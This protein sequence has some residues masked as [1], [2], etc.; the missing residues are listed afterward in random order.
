MS[1]AQ[2]SYGKCDEKVYAK[3]KTGYCSTHYYRN[4]EGRNM[5][6]PKQHHRIGV[7]AYDNVMSQTRPNGDC[8][9]FTGFIAS[10]GY[11]RI[12]TKATGEIGAH[13]VIAEKHL[14]KSNLT[15]LHSC[16][17]PKCVNIKHL[18]YG[19]HKENG[20]D[21]AKRLRAK[22]GEDNPKSYLNEK[23][24]LSI[25]HDNRVARVIAEEYQCT[26]KTVSNIKTHR[27]WSWLTTAA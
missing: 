2:C 1:I 10:N 23:Q 5:D 19:T 4:K 18:R 3:Y 12:D 21:K 20:E 25:Y 6:A 13:R 9:E 11:G 14:G 17:N 26:R 16:D 22:R 24:V 27:T 7:S 8:I 15:V